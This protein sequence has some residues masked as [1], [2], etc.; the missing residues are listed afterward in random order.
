[1]GLFG[2]PRTVSRR[3]VP[4]DPDDRLKGPR[5]TGIAPPGRR[6]ETPALEKRRVLAIGHWSAAE[7]KGPDRNRGAPGLDSKRSP[8][9]GNCD[10]PEITGRHRQTIQGRNE[11]A[12][13]PILVDCEHE[14]TLPLGGRV[15]KDD[16]P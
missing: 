7:P 14:G 4:R 16:A 2:E 12:H 9:D 8:T 15:Y 3:F 13:M 11:L 10:R 1:A 6:L 5:E